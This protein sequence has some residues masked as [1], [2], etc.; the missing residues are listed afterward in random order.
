MQLVTVVGEPG[1]G[2][3]RIVAELFGY[4]DDQPELITWRQGRCLPYGEGITFWALG[5][6]VKAHAGILESD[7]ADDAV[8]EARRRAARGR[9]ARL[10]PPAAA[11][12]A[13]DRGVRHR[14][15][16][17]SCSR[18]GGGSSS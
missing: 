5:E 10:V 6:I 2:K 3:S 9:G 13:G 16:A 7:D 8:S 1:L 18:R 11:A 15:S 12:A 14:P 4:I 17:R